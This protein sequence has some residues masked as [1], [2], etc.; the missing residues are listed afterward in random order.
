MERE[1]FI[2]TLSRSGAPTPGRD[3]FA[4]LSERFQDSVC[5]N[6]SKSSHFGSFQ[7]RCGA[8]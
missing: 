5:S 7:I 2:S 8:A 4:I 1:N 3:F 6:R